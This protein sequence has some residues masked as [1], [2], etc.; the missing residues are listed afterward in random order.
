MGSFGVN[1]IGR[2]AVIRPG[3]GWWAPSKLYEIEGQC[4]RIGRVASAG[5]P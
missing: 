4:L 3:R 2:K 1:P 5:L